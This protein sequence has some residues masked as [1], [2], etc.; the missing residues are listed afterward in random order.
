MYINGSPPGVDWV[1]GFLHLAV[2]R[3]ISLELDRHFNLRS[4]DQQEY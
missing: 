1:A 3:G 2:S 4:P